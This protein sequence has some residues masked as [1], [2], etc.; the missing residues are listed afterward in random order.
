M[1]DKPG[2]SAKRR[3]CECTGREGNRKM[4]VTCSFHQI[5]DTSRRILLKASNPQQAEGDELKNAYKFC[6]GK[7]EIMRTFGIYRHTQDHN[8][9][10]KVKGC[11]TMN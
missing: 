6:V 11:F 4:K 9:Y 7:S 8:I 2:L 3:N 10:P 5:A 1:G